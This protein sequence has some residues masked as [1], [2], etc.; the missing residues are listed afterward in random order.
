MAGEPEK[1]TWMRL[2]GSGR[3]ARVTSAG[4]QRKPAVR[5]GSLITLWGYAG[6]CAGGARRERHFGGAR[7]G[8]VNGKG[9]Q[10]PAQ[11][12]EMSAGSRGDQPRGRQTTILA[13]RG[14]RAL[15]VKSSEF[16]RYTDPQPHREKLPSLVSELSFFQ[17]HLSHLERSTQVA[18]A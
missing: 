4:R 1:W 11:T 3:S 15:H 14:E 16:W 12:G 8:E 13:T 5:V 7:W 10:G 18:N 6:G 2:P 17:S 9:Q